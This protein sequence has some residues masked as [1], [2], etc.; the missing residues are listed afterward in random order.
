MIIIIIIIIIIITTFRMY[1]SLSGIDIP[2]VKWHF[3]FLSAAL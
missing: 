1:S 3:D 2:G